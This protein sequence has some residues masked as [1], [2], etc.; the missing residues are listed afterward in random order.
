MARYIVVQMELIRP[1]RPP[2]RPLRGMRKSQ[3]LL[4]TFYLVIEKIKLHQIQNSAFASDCHN[5]VSMKEKF[6]ALFPHSIFNPV[7]I[8]TFL[9]SC[10]Y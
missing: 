8:N 9:T 4:F 3:K 1:A 6:K 10:E 5:L 2:Q 7:F